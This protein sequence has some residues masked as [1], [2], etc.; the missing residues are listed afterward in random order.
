[1]TAP[2]ARRP[3]PGVPGPGARGG[4]RPPRR[5]CSAG[6]PLDVGQ[7]RQL[8]G[9]LDRR[10]ELPL[11]ACASSRQTARQDLAPLG[12]EA[13]QSPLILEI[14][15]PDTRLAD[16]AGLGGALH[17]SSSSSPVLATV[18]GTGWAP[19]FTTTRWR[20]T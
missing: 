16:G 18:T 15:D 14:D 1:P 3:P 4:H 11:V 10:A 6:E 19:S 20:N 8:P 5:G 17:S 13:R 12:Q 7:Q 2:A 9:A